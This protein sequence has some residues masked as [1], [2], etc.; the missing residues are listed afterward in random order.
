MKDFTRRIET[1]GGLTRAIQD[2]FS[3]A[4]LLLE[5]GK[6]PVLEVRTES[7]KRTIEQNKLQRKW[8]LEAQQQGDMTAEE[9]RGYC[10]LH[11]G[12]PMLIHELEGFKEKYDRH[13]RYLPYET[14]IALMMEPFDFPVSR[15]MNTEQST[16]YLDMVYQHL[17]G[18]GFVLTIPEKKRW[19]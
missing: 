13:I 18:L 9:Y 7:R 2:A 12:V 4:K 10:K 16:R 17:T 15:L 3:H 5:S 14:K 19:R 11:F 1:L 6:T 8:L